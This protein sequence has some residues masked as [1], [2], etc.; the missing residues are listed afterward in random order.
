MAITGQITLDQISIYE[1]DADPSASGF[2]SPIGAIASLYDGVNG[3]LWLKTGTADTAWSVIPKLLGGTNLAQGGL[4]FADASGNIVN[5][6]ARAYFDGA[7][8]F[9]FGANAPAVPQSTIHLDRGNAVGSHIRMTAGTTTG[10]AATD[11]TE[12]GI[13]DAGAAEIRQFENSPINFYTNNTRYLQLNPSGLLILG[14]NA[15]S[16]D[17]TGA[18][19]MPVFQ[20]IGTNATQMAAMQFSTDTIPAVFNLLKSRGSTVNTQGL[21]LADDELGRLQFRG[22]DGVNF[23][24]GASV[25]A[26]V[27]GTAA[28]G[29]MPGRISLQTTPSGAIVPVERMLID[30]KGLVRV[31][32]ALR[33]NREIKDYQTTVT[34]AGTLQ[35]TSASAGRQYF[36][37]STAGG[38]VRLPD[39]TTLT[40]GAHY[41]V[42]NSST[43]TV[44]L[45]NQAGTTLDLIPVVSGLVACQLQDNSTAAGVWN[46][47]ARFEPY[48]QEVSA[49]ASTSIASATYTNIGGMTIT[50]PAGTYLVM[51]STSVTSANANLTAQFIIQSNNVIVPHTQ[52]HVGIT[53]SN[54]LKNNGVATQGVVTVDGTQVIGVMWQRQGTGTISCTNR[55]MTIVR[56]G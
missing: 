17:I 45:Q 18:G 31:V 24:A 4:L 33:Y 40:V 48:Y 42:I 35:L 7:G 37:G 27:D 30:S 55:T 21:L 49:T 56:V 25:R 54:P 38:I 28:A 14:Q 5:N 16:Q 34:A 51:F 9:S 44:T 23:Q 39:A 26:A 50:P 19:A 36:T 8:R 53:S 2:S 6:T 1:V 3:K 10:V 32:D 11:G 15:T 13:D 43:A 20:I 41:E 52:R 22:S 46:T 47:R 12:F 29:S